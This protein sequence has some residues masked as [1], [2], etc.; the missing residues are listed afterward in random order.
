[1]SAMPTTVLKLRGKPVTYFYSCY[2]FK[3][4]IKVTR[5]VFADNS[6][7]IGI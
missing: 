4:F 5:I 3:S 2:F 7:A 6:L 1:M